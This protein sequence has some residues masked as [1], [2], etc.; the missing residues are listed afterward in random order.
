MANGVFTRQANPRAPES[1]YGSLPVNEKSGL[2]WPKCSSELG[3]HFHDNRGVNE[4]IY[5]KKRG[6]RLDFYAAL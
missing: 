6:T 3:A 5:T 4:Y 2:K 1:C